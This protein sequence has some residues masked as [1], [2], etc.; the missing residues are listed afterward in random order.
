LGEKGLLCVQKLADADEAEVTT[1]VRKH[2]SVIEIDWMIPLAKEIQRNHGGITPT[3]KTDLQT[4]NVQY[5]G[6]KAITETVLNLF[7]QDIGEYSLTLDLDCRK[8]V[9]ATE[10]INISEYL[11]PSQPSTIDMK[12][13]TCEHVEQSLMTW[14]TEPEWEHFYETLRSWHQILAFPA[15][16][17]KST[18]N[19]I[20]K[21]IEEKFSP[22]DKF[23]LYE[24]LSCIVAQFEITW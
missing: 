3:V 21:K 8:L 14:V 10:L 22:S 13:V 23:L 6:G 18:I 11:H 1:T 12:L 5:G 24:A 15:D 17:K 16:S 9:V 2:S 4:L 19:N 20:E 7:L